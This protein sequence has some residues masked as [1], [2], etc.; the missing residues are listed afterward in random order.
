MSRSLI[1]SMKTQMTNPEPLQLISMINLI[2]KSPEN[3]PFNIKYS[4]LNEEVPRKHSQ[5]NGRLHN[6]QI[7]GYLSNIDYS[8]TNVD[9]D[10]ILKGYT[11][12]S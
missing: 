10:G 7:L 9:I 8:K 6:L 2:F 3:C 5:V 12:Y 11:K 4:V 1:I